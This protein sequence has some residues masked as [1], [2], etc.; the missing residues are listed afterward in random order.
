M[1]IVDSI[2][3]TPLDMSIETNPSIVALFRDTTDTD[4]R[5]YYQSLLI[6]S[7]VLSQNPAMSIELV[8]HVSSDV[9]P[10]AE[11][12]AL[13]R[14][15]QVRSFLIANGVIASQIIVRSEGSRKPRYYFQTDGTRRLLNNRVE[16]RI[17]VDGKASHTITVE[18]VDNEQTAML[19][20]KLWKDRKLNAYFEPVLEDGMTRYRIKLWGFAS[21]AEAKTVA[22]DIKKYKPTYSIVE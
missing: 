16:A 5:E 2:A 1:P 10:N 18:Q 22:A 11:A 20:M 3:L 21:L 6:I 15:K 13:D 12:R 19:R 8:G 4:L 14:A 7:E 9:G 17:I